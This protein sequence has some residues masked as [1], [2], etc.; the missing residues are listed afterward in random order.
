MAMQRDSKLRYPMIIAERKTLI[1]HNF[2]V[3]ICP[4]L[5]S[6]V[7]NMAIYMYN[8]PLVCCERAMF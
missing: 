7:P 8:M 5:I 6:D 2:G 3:F 1:N 4:G